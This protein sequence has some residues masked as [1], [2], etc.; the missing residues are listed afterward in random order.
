MTAEL[1]CRVLFGNQV[2]TELV[3]QMVKSFGD[4]QAI[5]EQ[6]DIDTFL[7]LP[8]WVPNIKNR[9]ATK[10]AEAIHDI[11]DKAIAE[12]KKSGNANTLLA[13]FLEF[14]SETV[15]AK[16]LNR[17]QIRNELIVLFMAGV[18]TRIGPARGEGSR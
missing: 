18:E 7:G 1:V 9:K 5:V 13:Q 14:Q 10:A 12:G 17:E 11:V 6:V 16:T 3:A 8:S 15:T 2:S 4:Y